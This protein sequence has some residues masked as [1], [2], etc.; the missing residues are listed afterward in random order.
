MVI[1][2][3]DRGEVTQFELGELFQKEQ[4]GVRDYKQAF[5]WYLKAA[6]KGSRR[7]QHRVGT[8]YARGQGIRQSYTKAYAWCLIAATQNS[9]SAQRKLQIIVS[10]MRDDQINRGRKL[11]R[12]YYKRYSPD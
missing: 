5:N 9:K 12:K 4:F 7:A 8:L 6:K 10:K 1:F 11:A 3:E 2:A